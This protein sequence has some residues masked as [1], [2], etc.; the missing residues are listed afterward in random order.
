MSHLFGPV[1][2]IAYVVQEMDDAIDFWVNVMGCGPVFYFRSLRL[3]ARSGAGATA[4]VVDLALVQNGPVLVELVRQVN[5]APSVYRDFALR[6]GEGLHR[7]VYWTERFDED[8]ERALQHGLEIDQFN[9]SGKIP[10]AGE[11]TACFV[12]RGHA[13]TTLELCE[14]RPGGLHAALFH[15]VAEQSQHWSGADPVR[16]IDPA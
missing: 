9:S 8:V 11:R 13:G 2:Q 7:L 12:P 4:P 5:D 16:I 15:D 3:G 14:T 6:H 1:R 10:G